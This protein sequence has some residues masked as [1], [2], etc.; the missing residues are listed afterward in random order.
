[1]EM[2]YTPPPPDSRINDIHI[3]SSAITARLTTYAF[4]LLRK[5]QAQPAYNS[6]QRFRVVLPQRQQCFQRFQ[7]FHS[8]TAM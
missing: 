3:Y 7:R 5:S 8:S 1:M 6:Q 4:P 2:E